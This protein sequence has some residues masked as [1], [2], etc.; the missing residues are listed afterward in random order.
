MNARPPRR[1]VARKPWCAPGSPRAAEL[2]RLLDARFGRPADDGAALDELSCDEAAGA[3]R[4]TDDERERP[5]RGTTGRARRGV[6][7][8]W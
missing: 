8:S 6:A 1:T 4:R 5:T 2:R 7:G 3:E